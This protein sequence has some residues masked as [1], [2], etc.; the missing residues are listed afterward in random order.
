[1]VRVCS[2]AA[3]SVFYAILVVCYSFSGIA[4][5]GAGLMLP[6]LIFI[7]LGV[8]FVRSRG[9][10]SWGTLT[11]KICLAVIVG[12]MC[13]CILGI[14]VTIY[15]EYVVERQGVLYHT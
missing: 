7:P 5:Y 3:L 4:Y 15:E 6:T 9:L 14:A 12:L 2:Y 8:I 13:L 1:M 11:G 10:L